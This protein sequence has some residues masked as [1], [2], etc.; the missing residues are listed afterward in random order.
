MD[1]L[2]FIVTKLDEMVVALDSVQTPL[3]ISWFKL[4]VG[5][6]LLSLL[7]GFIIRATNLNTSVSISKMRSNFGDEI[8]KGSAKKK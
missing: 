2:I 6:L 3:G 1:Y 5:L 4:L 7:F 8:R